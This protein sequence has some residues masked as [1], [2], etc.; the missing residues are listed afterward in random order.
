MDVST[1]FG[2]QFWA[3]RIHAL[4]VFRIGFATI[5][6]RPRGAVDYDFGPRGLNDS[7]NG[8]R[9]C[10]VERLPIVSS[11]VV[12]LCGRVGCESATDQ[13]TRAGDQDFQGAPT[14]IPYCRA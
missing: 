14:S 11:Y 6:V 10:D 8:M 13:A 2:E 12:T 5:Y 3:K 4:G 1:V 7:V 9:V